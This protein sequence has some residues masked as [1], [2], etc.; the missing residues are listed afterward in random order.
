MTTRRDFTIG[1]LGAGVGSLLWPG[2]SGALGS[3]A[4]APG[5]RGA[6]A[7]GELADRVAASAGRLA[8]GAVPAFTPEFILADVAL[9]PPR[10]F[11]EFSGDLSGRYV[12]AFS[13]LPPDDGASLGD[14][15]LVLGLDV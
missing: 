4:T 8:R 6:V 11:N 3:S 7:A 10:R 1:M 14:E 5:A 15:L 12:E 13:L 2:P 9:E